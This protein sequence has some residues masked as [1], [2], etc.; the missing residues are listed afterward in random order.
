MLAGWGRGRGWG[1]EGRTARRYDEGWLRR[2]R[3]RTG[4]R[5]ADGR[6]MVEESWLEGGGEYGWDGGEW[7]GGVGEGCVAV[8]KG[9]R[10]GGCSRW[11]GT[12]RAR[13]R[14]KHWRWFH[15]DTPLVYYVEISKEW[16]P[17]TSTAVVGARLRSARRRAARARVQV[18]CTMLFLS[19]LKEKGKARRHVA[20]RSRMERKSCCEKV[21]LAVLILE[22]ISLS[23]ALCLPSSLLLFSLCP[24]GKNIISS[25]C[26]LLS[27]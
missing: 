3:E 6:A 27:K 12:R 25:S 7:N 24:K 11:K 22:T 9:K 2:S 17:R 23:L 10:R 26:C 8:F 18:F 14:S 5:D 21:T 13:G 20:A 15:Y 4:G 19:G 1:L 16:R